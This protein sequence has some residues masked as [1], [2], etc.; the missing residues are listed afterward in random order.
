[1]LLLLE[2]LHLPKEAAEGRQ[3][4][5]RVGPVGAA[6]RASPQSRPIEELPGRSQESHPYQPPEFS[7]E[8]TPSPLT[9]ITEGEK[10]SPQSRATVVSDCH[11]AE[12]PPSWGVHLCPLTKDHPRWAS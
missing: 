8:G 6:Q 11:P 4:H 9:F 1:M 3:D 7:G 2:S 12:Q 10:A 5:N